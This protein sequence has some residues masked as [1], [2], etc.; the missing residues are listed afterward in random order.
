MKTAH[1]IASLSIIMFTAAA[2]SSPTPL[3]TPTPTAATGTPPPAVSSPAGATSTALAEPT[4]ERGEVVKLSGDT[5]MTSDPFHI[6]SDTILEITWDYA[7]SGP[8]ALWLISVSEEVT[9]PQYDRMIIAD[10][11]GAPSGT[12]QQPVIAG[13]YAVQVE[14]ADGPWTVTIKAAP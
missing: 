2:C 12:A 3:P 9:D 1:A 6:D 7:G 8:F 5:F 14:Q 4:A 10:V 11:G 13:D